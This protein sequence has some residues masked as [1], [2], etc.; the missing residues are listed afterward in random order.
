MSVCIWPGYCGRLLMLGFGLHDGFLQVLFCACVTGVVTT[1]YL[2][3]LPACARSCT[4][5]HHT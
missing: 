1:C 5:Q 4:W 3:N 2:S